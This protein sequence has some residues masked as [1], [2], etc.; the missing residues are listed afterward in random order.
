MDLL[1]CLRG[2]RLVARAGFTSGE[3]SGTE[4]S[5]SACA[6]VQGFLAGNNARLRATDHSL[7]LFRAVL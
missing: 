6:Q 5:A 4:S 3:K 1:A 2:F 7:G